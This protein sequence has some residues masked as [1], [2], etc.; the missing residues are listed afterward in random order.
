MSRRIPPLATLRAVEA[1]CR[2]QSYSLAANEL[3][4][5][6]GA[7]SQQITKLETEL[8]RKLFTRRGHRMV[9][10]EPALTLASRI[11]QALRILERG[12]SE[13]D[14]SGAGARLALSVLP[15]F[16][17]FWLTPRLGQLARDVE[18]L[19]LDFRTERR[20]VDL[21]TEDVDVAVRIGDGTWPGLHAELLMKQ[22]RFPV[23]T[24]EI[25]D[26][27][28][29]RQPADLARAPLLDTT[30]PNWDP[31]LI[32]VRRARQTDTLSTIFD[33]ASLVLQA[34]ID[35]HGVAIAPDLLVEEALRSGKLVR[36]FEGQFETEYAYYVVWVE[37]SPKTALIERFA[38]WLHA[39]AA[40]G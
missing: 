39:Q 32:D 4:V 18:G 6:H 14:A 3:S 35:G 25:R 17:R 34:A 33:D 24:A 38:A 1:A 7:I 31:W 28:D 13:A 36:L 2:H 8:G 27:Y 9:P 29:L 11:A 37:G 21:R 16:G 12:M 22:N 19:I 26:Q 30:D 40:S 20:L 5:T 10:T 23:A 15:S